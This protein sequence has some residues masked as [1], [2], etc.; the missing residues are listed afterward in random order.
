MSDVDC[1]ILASILFVEVIVVI[2]ACFES[3]VVNM[4]SHSSE[5]QDLWQRTERR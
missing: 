3:C 5:F 1:L 4:D 2:T